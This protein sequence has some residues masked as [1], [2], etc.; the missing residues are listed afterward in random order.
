MSETTPTPLY[1]F[2]S[3]K[4]AED[5]GILPEQVTTEFIHE[6]RKRMHQDP[7]F[8]FDFSSELLRDPGIYR[9]SLSWFQLWSQLLYKIKKLFF[10]S[11]DRRGLLRIK[12]LGVS[13]PTFAEEEEWKQKCRKWAQEILQQGP[14]ACKG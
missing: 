14:T 7:Q 4:I 6:M 9:Y 13:F 11:M 3:K 2:F 10:N 1:E 12:D 8:Q 5:L